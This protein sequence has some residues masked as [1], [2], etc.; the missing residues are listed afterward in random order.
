MSPIR[1][2]A[3]EDI[4]AELFPAL[5]SGLYRD[6]LDALRE[7]IQNSIDAKASRIEIELTKDVVSV[8]DNGIGMTRDGAI[9]AIRLG[10]SD[11][12]PLDN[13][14]FRGIGIYSSFNLCDNLEIHT[15]H[16]DGSASII[17]VAFRDVRDMLEDEEEK[18]KLGR[19]SSLHL[20]KMMSQAVAVDDDQEAPLQRPGTLVMMIGV[21]AAV[22]RQLADLGAVRAY[23]RNTVPLPFAPDFRYRDVITKK[24]KDTDYRVVDLVLRVGT[25]ASP[26]YRPYTD[27]VFVHGGQFEPRISNITDRE[28]KEHFGFVWACLNDARTVLSD[29][30]LRG[31][32]V[33]KY[34]FSIANREYLEPYFSKTV[35]YRRMTGEVIAQHRDLVP[36]AARSDF[37]NNETRGR[38]RVALSEVISELQTWGTKIQNQLKAYEVLDEA[39]PRVFA[40]NKL[41]PEV[42]TDVDELMKL[43]VELANI[44]KALSLYKPILAKD[45]KDR[46]EQA[47]EVLDEAE[48][49]IQG[50][51]SQKKKVKP[52]DLVDRVADRE[53]EEPTEEETAHREDRPRTLTDALEALDIVVTEPMRLAVA[54]IDDRLVKPHLSPDQ[55]TAELEALREYL[56]ER[57]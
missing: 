19:P 6:P 33:K 2:F 25:Q 24:F 3:P 29:R 1:R 42:R 40:I 7:Y 43:I 32:L 53:G 27:D 41:L 48:K 54:Y 28:T 57:A 37:E 36:N 20:E 14:G 45:R 50:I 34:G 13:V 21:R 9:S 10:M 46:L 52:R 12:N 18:R 35:L 5:T 17:T 16:E 26:L 15:R 22:S 56:E 44:R 38:F 8:R 55:Y 11:K 49:G 51:L 30:E 4:G 31:L 23:L 47:V 39:Q